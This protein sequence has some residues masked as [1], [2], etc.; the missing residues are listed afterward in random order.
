[1]SDK[2]IIFSGP[3]VRAILEGTKTQTRRVVK[4]Q[5]PETHVICGVNDFFWLEGKSEPGGCPETTCPHGQPGDRLWVR[6][7]HSFWCHSIEAVGV[8][9]AAGGE[10]KIVE[11]PHK[12]GMPSL[13]VQLRRNRDGARKKRPSIYMP[14]W[15]SRLTLEITAVRVE[16][17]R[18][19]SEEDA[20][21]EG[22][23]RT[24]DEHGIYSA[25]VAYCELWESIHG[26]GSW[27]LNPWVWV[28]EFR[29]VE[30]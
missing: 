5:P 9:Y 8:E 18:D 3:M 22:C 10:D 25:T 7:T 12:V 27:A 2:P 26:A 29:R 14:R 4:P 13:A 20:K 6:E 23:A 30:S 1:M 15:A 24:E 19:I 28:I 21:A 16:R 17:L 11:F